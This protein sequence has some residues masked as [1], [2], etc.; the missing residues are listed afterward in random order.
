MSD[1]PEDDDAIVIDLTHPYEA[2][3]MGRGRRETTYTTA[4]HDRL[5]DE[6][7]LSAEEAEAIGVSTF[8]DPFRIHE[9]EWDVIWSMDAP[10]GR[11]VEQYLG[12]A[13]VEQEVRD[14]MDET[15]PDDLE[16]AA[17]YEEQRIQAS[18]TI[19]TWLQRE[20]YDP[21]EISGIGPWN[22]DSPFDLDEDDWEAMTGTDPIEYLGEDQILK[23]ADSYAGE[24]EYGDW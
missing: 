5:H 15:V 23:T 16:E 1:E 12:Q 14:R 22:P 9:R 10:P 8:T 17:A 4:F 19:E 21:V 24:Q 18:R 3:W 2:D 20:G 6:Y 13:R 11:A 7:G